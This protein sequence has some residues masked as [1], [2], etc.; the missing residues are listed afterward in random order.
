MMFQLNE[1]SSC[2]AIYPSDN[3]Q[4]YDYNYFEQ[5]TGSKLGNEPTSIISHTIT[6]N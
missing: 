1:T 5:C 2:S 6:T 4:S 3:C